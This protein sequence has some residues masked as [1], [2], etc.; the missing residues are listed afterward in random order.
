M[1]R[2]TFLLVLIL[3]SLSFADAPRTFS[4]AKKIGWELYAD[5]PV[6]FYCGCLYSGNKVD[7]RSCGYKPRKNPKRASRVEWEHIVSAWQ[8]G[9]Q[10]KC[11]QNGGRANCAKNDAR[12]RKAEADLHNLVPAIGEVNADRSNYSFGWSPEKPV[13]YGACQTVVD[14]KERRVMPRQEIRGFVART[15]FYMSKRY[16]L[17]LSAQDRK[18]YDVWA[19]AYPPQRWEIARNERIACI[20]GNANEFVSRV[21]LRQCRSRARL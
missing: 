19:K 2:F 20:S 18:L 16:G 9:H 14:F 8:I 13:Q 11:W 17:R 6:E 3:P 7:L 12:Y 1:L 21:D 5:T 15:H 10:R 4:E